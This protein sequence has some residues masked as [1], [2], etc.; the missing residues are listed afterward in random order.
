MKTWIT[1]GFSIDKLKKALIYYLP[2][3]EEKINNIFECIKI[4]DFII[5]DVNDI[6]TC[7]QY[8]MSDVL[9]L[10]DNEFINIIN[11]LSRGNHKIIK[12]NNGDELKRFE[13]VYISKYVYGNYVSKYNAV[14]FDDITYIITDLEYIAYFTHIK[15]IDFKLY[16]RSIK[17]KQLL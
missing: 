9:Y 4:N 5:I 3:K 6:Y 11:I 10:I 2:N 17:L 1:V 15:R 14:V 16:M 12:I 7:F 8:D 13:N